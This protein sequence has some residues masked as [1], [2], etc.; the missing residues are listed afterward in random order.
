[1]PI[2]RPG[3]E[4]VFLESL[5]DNGEQDPPHSHGPRSAPAKSPARDTHTT[6]SVSVHSPRALL[7]DARA[8]P[9]PHI[10]TQHPPGQHSHL[11]T[12][13][14]SRARA[15]TLATRP[16]CTFLMPHA[17]PPHRAA[18][19]TPPPPPPA[20]RLQGF[21]CT[22]PTHRTH[23]PQHLHPLPHPFHPKPTPALPP[24]PPPPPPH[25]HASPLPPASP[26]LS[27]A[28]PHSA[29]TPVALTFPRPHTH[30]Q[31]THLPTL[32]G[33]SFG[34]HRMP[35]RLYE[36][37]TKAKKPFKTYQ[38]HQPYQPYQ[39]YQPCQPYQP[40]QTRN[41]KCSP[42]LCGR[43]RANPNPYPNPNP[44]T[45]L[46]LGP[47]LRGRR[48]ANP[49]PNPNPYPDPNPDP[50]PNPNPNPNP[51]P[52]PPPG[53]DPRTPRCKAAISEKMPPPPPPPPPGGGG[54]DHLHETP[55]QRGAL[56]PPLLKDVAR[57]RPL[58]PKSTKKKHCTQATH[59]PIPP[60]VGGVEPRTRKVSGVSLA[61]L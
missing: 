39:P 24:L 5:V 3:V 35:P 33:R 59:A 22:H 54:G 2:C 61:S 8:R 29:A 50:N 6:A 15:P 38:P 10:D 31:P 30:A 32:P 37:K 45:S 51:Y 49:N 46:A 26:P 23:S 14:P 21:P 47:S 44:N 7:H 56:V 12:H 58:V 40:Y 53:P 19:R 27:H 43:H 28:S 57:A 4:N 11:C 60:A 36:M 42:E 18:L 17:R 52:N 13:A 20:T 34:L 55:P 16:I 41:H 1:M 25:V 48:R 9:F